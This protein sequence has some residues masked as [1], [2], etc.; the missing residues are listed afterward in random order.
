MNLN[1]RFDKMHGIFPVRKE[2]FVHSKLI[3]F[4][5]CLVIQFYIFLNKEKVNFSNSH[6]QTNNNP[7]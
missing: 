6:L 7:F 3:G 5:F 1:G 4:C 2:N